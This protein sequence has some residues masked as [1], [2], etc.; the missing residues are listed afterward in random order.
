VDTESIPKYTA[1]IRSCIAMRN[2]SGVFTR[3][4]GSKKDYTI[5][6]KEALNKASFHTYYEKNY[7]VY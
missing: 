6:K 3:H 4:A 2:I 7:P 1:A 5:K